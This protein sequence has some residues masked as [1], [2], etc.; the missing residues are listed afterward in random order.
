[1]E[2]A[3][4]ENGTSAVREQ[5]GEASQEKQQSV[6]ALAAEKERLEQEQQNC[7]SKVYRTE[8]LSSLMKGVT[9]LGVVLIILCVTLGIFIS[10]FIWFGI[11]FAIVTV[12]CFVI[13]RRSARRLRLLRERREELRQA[14]SEVCGRYDAAQ[15]H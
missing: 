3:K 12:I 5:P 14:Y 8:F 2:E 15:E 1:M 6:S 7:A 10:N 4:Q 13:Y 9:V 11:T